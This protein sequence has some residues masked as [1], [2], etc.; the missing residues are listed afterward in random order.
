MW[1][2]NVAGAADERTPVA[3]GAPA[4]GATLRKL[5]ASSVQWTAA[6]RDFIVPSKAMMPAVE[7]GPGTARDAIERACRLSRYARRTL[8]SQPALVQ[9]LDLTRAFTAQAMHS[10]IRSADPSDEASLMKALRE[11]RKRVL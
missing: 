4:R 3:S 7:I 8:Q 2:S 10:T 6:R 9:T 5:L 11:L 1:E